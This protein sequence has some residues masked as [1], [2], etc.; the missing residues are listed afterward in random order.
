M[1]GQ[2][3]EQ[4]RGRKRGRRLQ[5]QQP[6][7]WRKQQQEND[8]ERQNIHIRRLELEQQR[9]DDGDIGLLEKIQNIHL[10]GI[11]RV[12]ETASD[13]CYLG[14]I[15]REQEDMSDIDL[16]GPSQ[17]MRTRDHE[18]AFAHFPAVNESSGI[19]R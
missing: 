6:E 15:N 9:L 14:K 12:L 3:V 16:P 13:V 8:I 5:A 19:T 10:L 18:S 17:N 2:H 1:P 4:R 7:G 11:E